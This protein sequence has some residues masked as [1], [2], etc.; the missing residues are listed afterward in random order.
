MNQTSNKCFVLMPFKEELK[1]IYLEIYKP[2]CIEL[3]FDCW[4]VDEI[5]RPGSI[6]K[7][8]V[9]GIVD[10]DIIIADLTWSNPNVFY[11]LGIAHALNKKTIMTC[12]RDEKIPFDISNYRVI[13]YQ[14]T[15]SG[16]KELSKKLKK[17]INEMVASDAAFSNPVTDVLPIQTFSSGDIRKTLSEILDYNEITPSVRRYLYD[18]EV[19]YPSDV[20]KINFDTMLKTKNIG[21]SSVKNFVKQLIDKNLIKENPYFSKFLTV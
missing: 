9:Q 4:R 20:L 16:C 3:G 15:L 7:D 21:K 12:Q 1:E 6:T 18:N 10:S 17:S 8:I 11:E 5:S 13:I 14:H 19:I 2:I